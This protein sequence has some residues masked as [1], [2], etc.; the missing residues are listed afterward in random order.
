MRRSARGGRRRHAGREGREAPERSHGDRQ[1]AGARRLAV[2]DPR[3]LP[4]AGRT[5]LHAVAD[6]SAVAGLLPVPDH[7]RYLSL[8][9]LLRI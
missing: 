2:T 6:G 7:D 3:H 8:A 5:D 9:C 1:L 4:V